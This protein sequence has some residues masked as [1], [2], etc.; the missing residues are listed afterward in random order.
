MGIIYCYHNIITGK[1]YIGQTTTQWEQYRKSYHKTIGNR[2]PRHKSKF[3]NAI[4]CYGWETF[5]YGVIEY[6][7]LANLDER[8]CY[9]IEQH[10]CV[11]NGYNILEGG[12]A[13]R[14]LKMPEHTKQAIIKAN[15]G[16]PM[17]E[18]TRQAIIN[19]NT[20]RKI[21]EET[22]QK[23][24]VSALNRDR[25]SYNFKTKHYAVIK[26]NGEV[27]IVT[28]MSQYCLEH[29]ITKSAFR[30]RCLSTHKR[31]KGLER[32]PKALRKLPNGILYVLQLHT[33]V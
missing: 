5:I 27:D 14:G 31:I 1:K 9:W 19:A 33:N 13:P 4:K 23:L 3:Q 7:D 20:G 32:K 28:R 17:N 16:R 10:D 11:N 21:T 18:R 30:T 24:R 6:T 22:R 25:S 8:E 12:N 15:T 26:D 29:N 2:N